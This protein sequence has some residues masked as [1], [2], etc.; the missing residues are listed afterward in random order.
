MSKICAD[1]RE[2]QSSEDHVENILE[3]DEVI[4]MT[5][6]GMVRASMRA[7][8]RESMCIEGSKVGV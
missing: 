3:L 7:H 6:L 2:E 8:R 5:A 4:A 1:Y